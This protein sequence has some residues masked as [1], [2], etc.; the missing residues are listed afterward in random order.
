MR[1][2]AI[3]HVT[4]AVADVEQA[5]DFYTRVV[6]LRLRTDRPA[7]AAAGAWLDV[8]G[9]QVHLVHADPPPDRGQHMALLVPDLDAAVHALRAA[10]AV[11]TVPLDAARRAFL[12]D[13]SGNAIELIAPHEE[14]IAAQ[15]GEA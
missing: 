7:T 12:T 8:G 15:E 11:V 1:P 14:P 3:H 9:Q 6:G 10:G 4:L 13:P 5:V 2:L